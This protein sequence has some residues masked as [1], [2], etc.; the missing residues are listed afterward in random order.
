MRK[1]KPDGAFLGKTYVIANPTDGCCNNLV[2]YTPPPPGNIGGP[3]YIDS[4]A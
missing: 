2:L 3:K 1:L 4:S